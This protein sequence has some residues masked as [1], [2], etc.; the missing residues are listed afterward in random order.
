M[1]RAVAAFV[2]ALV[3]TT[4]AGA[5][6]V[7]LSCTAVQITVGV[8]REGGSS[9]GTGVDLWVDG[10]TPGSS[11]GGGGTAGRTTHC[12][13]VVN[14][15]CQ[16]SSPSKK[17]TLPASVRDVASFRPRTPVQSM[18][19]AGWGI[20][21][22]PLNFMSGARTHVVSGTLLGRPASVR[23]IPIRYRRDFGDSTSMST[24]D[25]G[26]TWAARGLIPWSSTGTSHAY[27]SAGF[28]GVTLVVDYV[29]DYRFS[30]QAWTRLAGTVSA[31]ANPL[32]VRIA[33][34][35]TVLVARP[36]AAGAVGCTA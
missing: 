5:P 33:R 20:V 7:A 17:V 32:S 21:G 29:A 30:T 24:R 25:P 9:N 13:T 11:S 34:A 12:P 16:G 23:F 2:V 3:V 36:C 35:S 31:R 10:R 4:G 18:E 27:A 22:V 28:F 6:A 8:C 19:P 14:G 26:D 15:R 1:V